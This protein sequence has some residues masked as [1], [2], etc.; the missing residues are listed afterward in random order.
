[1]Q[2]AAT[3]LLQ[4]VEFQAEIMGMHGHPKILATTVGHNTQQRCTALRTAHTF[5]AAGTLMLMQRVLTAL[6]V[7]S[8]PLMAQ[9]R[10]FARSSSLGQ[11][12]L[13]AASAHVQ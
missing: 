8:V 13:P 5:A 2:C 11:V 1:M 9:L 4:Q 3:T 6:P 7:S 10:L 12:T